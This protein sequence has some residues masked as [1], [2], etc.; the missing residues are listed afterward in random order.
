MAAP[1]KNNRFWIGWYKTAAWARLR[2]WQLQREP[3]CRF[4]KRDGRIT[5]A[6]TVDHVTP[7]RG[8]KALFFDRENL[9][10]LCKPCHSSEKQRLEK[11]TIKGCDEKGIVPAW[12]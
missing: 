12:Q 2:K 8:D 9:Q 7:H 5:E 3:I 11:E 10:S 1:S 6:N 4:C